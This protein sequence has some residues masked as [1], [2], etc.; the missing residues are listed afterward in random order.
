MEFD[1][2]IVTKIVKVLKN[3][4]VKIDGFWYNQSIVQM[5]GG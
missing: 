1:I 5:L 2:T 4:V 3:L